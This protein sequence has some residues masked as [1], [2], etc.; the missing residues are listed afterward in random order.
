MRQRAFFKQVV[1]GWKDDC[2][3]EKEKEPPSGSWLKERIYNVR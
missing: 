2:H 1:L 3:S